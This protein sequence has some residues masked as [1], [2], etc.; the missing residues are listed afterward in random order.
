[1]REPSGDH[2]G[3]L[4]L[5]AT[6]LASAPSARVT[7]IPRSSRTA[8]PWVTAGWVVVVVDGVAA[9][10]NGGAGGRPLP[11]RLCQSPIT[12]TPIWERITGVG[13]VASSVDGTTRRLN[14]HSE[15]LTNSDAAVPAH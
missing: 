6:C 13:E 5:G 9:P 12:Y 2:T 10:S 4:P 15:A 8:G 14:R 7:Q 1:M 11:V 3:T